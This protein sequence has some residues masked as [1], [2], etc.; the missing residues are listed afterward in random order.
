[1]KYEYILNIDNYLTM[2]KKI[3]CKKIKTKGKIMVIF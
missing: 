2:Y 1:M 3:F